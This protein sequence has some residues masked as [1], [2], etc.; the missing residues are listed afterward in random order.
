[1]WNIVTITEINNCLPPGKYLDLKEK[2]EG[3]ALE[4]EEFMEHILQEHKVS[5]K[6]ENPIDAFVLAILNIPT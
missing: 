6:S 3:K 5:L 1:M 2:K 4:E